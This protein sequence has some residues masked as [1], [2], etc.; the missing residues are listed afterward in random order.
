M[1]VSNGSRSVAT[2]PT[3]HGA[4]LRLPEHA[5]RGRL[6]DVECL[7]RQPTREKDDP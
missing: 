5:R 1:N 6:D 2:Q 4:S 7:V 3:G